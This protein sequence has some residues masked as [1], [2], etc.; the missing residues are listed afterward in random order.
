HTDPGMSNMDEEKKLQDSLINGYAG[1]QEEQAGRH[2]PLNRQHDDIKCP[3]DWIGH[4]GHCYKFSEEEKNWNESWNFCILHNAFLTKITN[5]EMDFVRKFTRDHIF[6]I[7]LKREPNQS[8]KWPDGDNA[9]YG[10]KSW[11]MM[12]KEEET[13]RI[14]MIVAK[15][16]QG[17]AP[18]N[19]ASSAKKK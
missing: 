3:L 4:Q 16:T 5:K 14:W 12:E 2:M 17:H 13:V 9:T 7:G 8:W 19:T 15:P 6:W 11:G 10:R 18:P 1:G